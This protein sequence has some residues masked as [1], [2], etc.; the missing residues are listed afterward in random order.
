MTPELAQAE[1]IGQVARLAH[2]ERRVVRG[3]VVLGVVQQRVGDGAREDAGP[4]AVGEQHRVEVVV[5]RAEAQ[6]RV[7]RV[8][9]DRAPRGTLEGMPPIGRLMANA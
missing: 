5:R 6:Q 1:Q 2:L 8:V 4:R 9:L 3:A 7:P